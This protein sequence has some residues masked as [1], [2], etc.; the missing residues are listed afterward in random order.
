MMKDSTGMDS[1]RTA[2]MNSVM[3][4]RGLMKMGTTDKGMMLRAL[5]GM[6]CQE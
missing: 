3:I 1:I 2:G 4:G 6:G 5:I